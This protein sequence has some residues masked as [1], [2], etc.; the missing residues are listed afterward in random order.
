MDDWGF[1]ESFLFLQVIYGAMDN[2]PAFIVFSPVGW[3]FG[4]CTG[5][6]EVQNIL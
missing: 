5:F 4:I 3:N 2:I 1:I 6:C